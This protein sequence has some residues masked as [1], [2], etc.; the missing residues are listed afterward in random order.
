MIEDGTGRTPWRFARGQAEETS[1]R[2][3]SVLDGVAVVFRPCAPANQLHT[4]PPDED[5]SSVRAHM[6]AKVDAHNQTELLRFAI[7]RNLVTIEPPAEQDRPASAGEGAT[8]RNARR[9]GETRQD[10]VEGEERME[11]DSSFRT[12]TR[13]TR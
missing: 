10:P 3:V 8:D 7:Y 12:A 4:N 1:L 11:G 2:P 6:M 5:E 9:L 13:S